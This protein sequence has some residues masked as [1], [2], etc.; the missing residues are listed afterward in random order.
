MVGLGVIAYGLL[1]FTLGV[2]YLRI[3]DHRMVPEAIIEPELN[4]PVTAVS[5]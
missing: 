3:V 5:H 2:R 4:E 1:A